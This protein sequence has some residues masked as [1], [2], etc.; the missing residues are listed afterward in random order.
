MPHFVCS[1]PTLETTRQPVITGR[2]EELGLALPEDRV[3]RTKFLLNGN[4]GMLSGPLTISNMNK[5]ARTIEDIG[6]L[7]SSLCYKL[8]VKHAETLNAK[9]G[10]SYRKEE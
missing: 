1:C 8:H 5:L 7:C 3:W 10:G 4:V 9:S 6:M 2:L